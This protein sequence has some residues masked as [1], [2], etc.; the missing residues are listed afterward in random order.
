MSYCK[1]LVWLS[2]ALQVPLSPDRAAVC[3][4]PAAPG[5][6]SALRAAVARGASG[7]RGAVP[8]SLPPPLGVASLTASSF[9]PPDS[10][11]RLVSSPWQY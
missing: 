11:A 10:L 1:E 5:G 4:L 7:R 9:L 6:L 3:F 8:G 2:A